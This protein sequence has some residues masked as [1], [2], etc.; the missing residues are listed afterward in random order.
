MLQQLVLIEK[1][2][3]EVGWLSVSDLARWMCLI[4]VSGS[5]REVGCAISPHCTVNRP[6]AMAIVGSYDWSGA[7]QVNNPMSDV[8]STAPQRLQMMF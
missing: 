5:E 7:S 1:V 8:Y 6:V 3:C 2:S 4:H